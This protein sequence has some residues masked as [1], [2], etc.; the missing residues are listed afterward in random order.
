MKD[1]NLP[2]DIK[3]K[4]LSEL[5]QEANNIIE[6]LEKEKNLENSLE[7]YQKLI[8]LNNIIEKKFQ[9][10]SKKISLKT[11]DKISQILSNKK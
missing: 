4:S 7:D 5:T 9:N 11:R 10:S 3:S 6:Q 1:K 8:K 2:D